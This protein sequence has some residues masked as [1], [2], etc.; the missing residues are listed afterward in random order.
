MLEKQGGSV[1]AE[2]YSWS[3]GDGTMIAHPNGES[4]PSHTYAEPG[5]Y[6]VRLEVAA[7]GGCEAGQDLCR[8]DAASASAMTDA[9]AFPESC[10]G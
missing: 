4:M 2:S 1:G 9:T 7:G 10:D 3:F 5:T 8:Y 6:E